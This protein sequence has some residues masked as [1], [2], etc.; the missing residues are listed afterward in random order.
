MNHVVLS[1]VTRHIA[2]QLCFA[3]H[4][5]TSL[6]QRMAIF[7]MLRFLSICTPPLPFLFRISFIEVGRARP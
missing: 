2:Q 6:F 1:V 4:V 3:G 7:R 5:Y